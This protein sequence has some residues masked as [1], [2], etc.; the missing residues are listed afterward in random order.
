MERRRESPMTFVSSYMMI[1]I[2]N[3]MYPSIGIRYPIKSTT[4]YGEL[5]KLVSGLGAY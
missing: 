5:E 2:S 1:L 3:W 4:L